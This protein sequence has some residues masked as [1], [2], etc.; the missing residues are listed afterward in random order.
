[1][2]AICLVGENWHQ[3]I[4]QALGQCDFGLLLLSYPFLSSCD[5]AD[6]EF[7]ALVAE[8]KALP[9]DLSRIALG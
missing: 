8:G 4:Q 6:H 5:M 1:M 2:T 7:L 9:V 3:A